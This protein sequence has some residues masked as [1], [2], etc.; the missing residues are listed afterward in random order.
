MRCWGEARWST[1][2]PCYY[3]IGARSGG[4]TFA[5]PPGTKPGRRR[6]CDGLRRGG[7]VGGACLP[8][9]RP[10][11]PEQPGTLPGT[12]TYPPRLFGKPPRNG[13]APPE[14]PFTLPGTATYPPRYSHLP[15]PP[16]PRRPSP[17][18]QPITL[19]SFT[20]TRS[21]KAKSPRYSHLA[22]PVSAKS[23]RYSRLPSPA[24]PEPDPKR[25]SP[26]GTATYPARLSRDAPPNA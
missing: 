22:S 5:D 10:S 3:P 21:G 6:G 20:A 8:A 1:F 25:Q 13:Q 2:E 9:K 16:A 15:S 23:P 26:P 24:S 12:V 19:P 18:E 7:W 14:Q 17:P 4:W 11:P